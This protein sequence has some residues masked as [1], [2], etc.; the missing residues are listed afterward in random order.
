[1]CDQPLYCTPETPQD[2]HILSLPQHCGS[3]DVMKGG[4]ELCVTQLGPGKKKGQESRKLRATPA[5]RFSVSPTPCPSPGGK[6]GL[7]SASQRDKFLK[8]TFVQ[9]PGLACGLS[10]WTLWHM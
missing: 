7:L 8:Q 9:Q 2:W 5:P 4:G 10:S 6:M 3:G 1:M